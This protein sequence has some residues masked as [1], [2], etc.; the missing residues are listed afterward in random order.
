MSLLFPVLSEFLL[1]HKSWGAPLPAKPSD[2]GQ[3]GFPAE[4]GAAPMTGAPAAHCSR[5]LRQSFEDLAGSDRKHH[6]YVPVLDWTVA[7]GFWNRMVDGEISPC[8]LLIGNE[9]RIFS[10]FVTGPGAFPA[11]VGRRPAVRGTAPLARLVHQFLTQETSL[12]SRLLQPF[13][14]QPLA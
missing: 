9:F 1:N 11:T 13:E 14:V 6:G 7:D 5:L 4:T 8:K 2:R 12:L 3:F 10:A